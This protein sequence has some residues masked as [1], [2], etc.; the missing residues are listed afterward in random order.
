M[1]L[2]KSNTG[3]PRLGMEGEVRGVTVV[4][5]VSGWRMR[6]GKSN[7]GRP[8]VRIEGEVGKE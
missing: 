8:R 6:L 5:P 4:D 3:R 1:R 2:A 7:T